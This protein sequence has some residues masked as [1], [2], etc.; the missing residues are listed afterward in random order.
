VGVL[1]L[2]EINHEL[3]SKKKDWDLLLKLDPKRPTV[4]LTGSG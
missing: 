1:S 3:R 2:H 4:G